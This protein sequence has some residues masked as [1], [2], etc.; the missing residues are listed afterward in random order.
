MN[1]SIFI[2]VFL[3]LFC[4]AVNATMDGFPRNHHRFHYKSIT[5]YGMSWSSCAAASD[6][7]Q[8]HNL[9]LTPDPIKLPGTINIAA[10]GVISKT[11]TAP[12]KADLTVSKKVFGAW[13]ELPCVDNVGSCTYNDICSMIPPYNPCPPPFSTYGIPC[14]CPFPDGTYVLPSTSLNLKVDIPSW[15]ENGAYKIHAKLSNNDGEV[16]CIDVQANLA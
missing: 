7:A 15:L 11:I 14:Q 2:F 16:Y 13:I 1:K 5:M 8:I 10:S 12:L 9:T 6:P 4:C 3:A